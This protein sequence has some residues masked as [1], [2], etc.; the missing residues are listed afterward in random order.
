MALLDGLNA[1]ATGP[2]TPLLE[3]RWGG[4]RRNA[5]GLQQQR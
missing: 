3:D 5:I 4:A 2:F 1:P